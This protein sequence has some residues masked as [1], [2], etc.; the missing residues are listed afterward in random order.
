MFCNTLE[1]PSDE[2]P[3]KRNDEIARFELLFLLVNNNKLAK[4]ELKKST[5]P[6]QPVMICT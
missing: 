5:F 3:L 1:I 2:K 6:L 4:I